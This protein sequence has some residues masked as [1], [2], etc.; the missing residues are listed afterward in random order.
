M[1]EAEPRPTP[2]WGRPVAQASSFSSP[3]LCERGLRPLAR[4]FVA[5]SCALS[6]EMKVPEVCDLENHK[7]DNG[8][9]Q[10]CRQCNQFMSCIKQPIASN[11]SAWPCITLAPT[12]F[13]LA[14]YRP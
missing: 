2:I 14:S 10:Q 7:C 6:S 12:A 11:S 13:A 9:D 4:G 3:A 1:P 8:D 5:V